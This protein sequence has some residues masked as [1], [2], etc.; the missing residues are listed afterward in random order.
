MFMLEIMDVG[1]A[2][3]PMS[4]YDMS[5]FLHFIIYLT[6]PRCEMHGREDTNEWRLYENA[7]VFTFCA[8]F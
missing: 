8:Y 3:K 2:F 5:S 6:K 4:C 1:I 7:P